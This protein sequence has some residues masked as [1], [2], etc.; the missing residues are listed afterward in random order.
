VEDECGAPEYLSG[1][2]RMCP[3]DGALGR[4]EPEHW[5][6]RISDRLGAPTKESVEGSGDRPN[7][8]DTVAYYANWS[9]KDISVGLSIYGALR[10]VQ[11]GRSAGTLWLNW[12]TERAAAPYLAEWRAACESLAV[13]AKGAVDVRTFS[14]GLDQRA[15]HG[16]GQE[17]K[18]NARL[19]REAEL[20]LTAPDILITPPLIAER[21]SSRTFAL[22][23]NRAMKLHCLST[24]W[25]SVIWDEGAERKV[26]WWHVLPAKGGGQSSL[27]V[28]N[29]S[30]IDH[31]D[32]R[33]VP[34]A[35]DALEGIPR[36]SVNRLEDYDC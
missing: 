2:G 12:S 5:I 20:A 25:D 18:G 19:K 16:N 14:L 30:V 1:G 34:A 33:G 4:V 24:R 36:V 17:P 11:E 35:A 28:G 27:H 7:P 23:S 8:W 10:E 15:H 9:G 22:W 21:L 31:T 3:V 29:W 13:A 32:S 6:R 26:D